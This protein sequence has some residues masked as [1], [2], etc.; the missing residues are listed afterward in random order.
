MCVETVVSTSCAR[1]HL[2]TAETVI[3][4]LHIQMKM[5]SMSFIG[6]GSKD[7][8]KML[9]AAWCARTT[10]S[11]LDSSAGIRRGREAVLAKRTGCFSANPLGR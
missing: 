11:D 8:A 10:K 5:I 9:Q 2:S 1:R 4:L 3:P 6:P 7:R